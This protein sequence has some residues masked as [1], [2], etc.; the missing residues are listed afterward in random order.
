MIEVEVLFFGPAKELAGVEAVHLA[1]PVGTTVQVLGTRLTDRIP[2]LRRAIGTMRTAVNA[3]FAAP[4][5]VLQS[6]DQVAL[7]PPVSGG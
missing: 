7:I 4:E 1:L 3:E 5:T 2:A 6:G